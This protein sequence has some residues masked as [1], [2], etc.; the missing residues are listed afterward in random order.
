MLAQVQLP[1]AATGTGIDINQI[2]SGSGGSP[3]MVLALGAVALLGGKT[4]W[5]FLKKRQE[6]A[7]EQKMEE[8]KTLQTGHEACQAKQQAL[9]ESLGALKNR[10][11]ELDSKSSA[12]EKKVQEIAAASEEKLEDLKNKVSKLKKKVVSDQVDEEEKKPRKKK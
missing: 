6:Q 3:L 11:S 1:A 4:L 8:L 9:E 5:D 10:I 2:I 7:H 12:S